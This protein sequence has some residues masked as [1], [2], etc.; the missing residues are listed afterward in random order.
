MDTLVK[1]NANKTLIAAME[2]IIY[3]IAQVDYASW[4]GTQQYNGTQPVPT[5]LQG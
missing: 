3:N 1:M 2:H 4:N 5:E